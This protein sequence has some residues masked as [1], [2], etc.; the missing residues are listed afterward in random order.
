M[1]KIKELFKT[2]PW[3]KH[4]ELTGSE[5]VGGCGKTDRSMKMFYKGKKR[6]LCLDCFI[7]KN[8]ELSC[9]YTLLVLN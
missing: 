1:D 4:V 7:D 2:S 3:L 9:R 5:C 8:E 6:N